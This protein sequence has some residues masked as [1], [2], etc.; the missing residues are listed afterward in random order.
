MKL[1]GLN[2]ELSKHLKEFGDW[3]AKNRLTEMVW[4]YPDGIRNYG[5]D[6]TGRALRHLEEI[7]E[8]AVKYEHGHS[9]YKYLYPEQRSSYIP[10][11]KRTDENLWETKEQ[12]KR[13]IEHRLITK[14]GRTFAVPVYG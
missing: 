3:K 1:R 13:F 9:F 14:N 6:Y 10:T 4:K 12:P 5:T 2:Y 7:K 11:S 8:I